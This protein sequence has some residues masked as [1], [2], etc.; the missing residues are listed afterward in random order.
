MSLIEGVGDE[1]TAV[2]AVLLLLFVICLAWISTNIRDIPFFSVIIVELTNGARRRA[3]AANRRDSP[4]SD[5]DDASSEH[6]QE[7]Q[8]V[9]EAGNV[10]EELPGN[11]EQSLPQ[12]VTAQA[13]NFGTEKRAVPESRTGE[14]NSGENVSGKDSS[15]ESVEQ[16]ALSTDLEKENS[17][18]KID[19]DLSETEL[20]R[21]RVEFFQRQ[22]SSK[23]P[24][25]IQASVNQGNSSQP[26]VS[27]EE[28]PQT[29]IDASEAA[30]CKASQSENS[31]NS[32]SESSDLNQSD[33][34]VIN[35][36][37]S[38][39]SHA[40]S[41]SVVN[42]G[43]SKGCQAD[44]KK[45]KDSTNSRGGNSGQSN[46]HQSSDPLDGES[47]GSQINIRL[48]Y[49]NDTQR[50]VI[51][52]PNDTIG[53]FRRANFAAE[54]SE[55]KLVRF[56]FNG[57]DLRN[58][59]NTL[60]AYNIVDNS[61]IHCL[62]TQANRNAE[63]PRMQHDDNVFD[64]GM[65]MLPLFGLL[66][67]LVWYLR[68]EYRQFFTATSTVSLI[69][70]L[71][72]N[73]IQV[74]SR[75][76]NDFIN[77]YLQQN[78]FFRNVWVTSGMRSTSNP[79]FYGWNGDY[80]NNLITP[81]RQ[82]WIDTTSS[83][84]RIGEIIVYRFDG[85]NYGWD[86]GVRIDKYSYICEISQTEAFRLNPEKRGFDY[87]VSF[88]DLDKVRR[89]PVFEA[90]GQPRDLTVI[91]RGLFALLECRA[92][93]YPQPNYKWMRNK[94][95]NVTND[96]SSINELITSDTDSRYTLTNGRFTIQSPAAEADSG[97]YVCVAE[98][99]VGKIISNPVT[100]S[101]GYLGEF[102]NVR[103][104]DVNAQAY[105]GTVIKCSNI[106][107]RPALIYN[108]RRGRNE[109]R[110]EYIYTETTP[111][112][113]MSYNGQLYFSEVTR[114]D[115]GL[116]YCQVSL[117][118]LGDDA[119]GLV[120]A[121]SRTSRGIRL[122]V[123]AQA[124]KTDW[125]PKIQDDFI[126]V[127]PKPPLKG[128]NVR[129]E[130]FAYGSA[131]NYEQM[132]SYS[133]IRKGKP[134]PTTVKFSDFNR[135][136]TIQ[137]AKLEDQGTYTCIVRRG[138]QASDT[139][140]YVLS[141]EA[142]PYFLIPLSHQ[143]AD[144]GSQLTWRCEASGYPPP[145]YRWYRNGQLL[146]SA[147]GDMI[148]SGSTL[149]IQSLDHKHSGMYQ[150]AASNSHGTSMSEA[151]LRV[152]YFAPK[153][154]KNP[155]KDMV[156]ALNG[157]ITIVCE[158]EAAPRPIITWKK[159]NGAISSDGRR[160]IL[161]NGNL[162]ILDLSYADRGFYTCQAENS[163]GKSAS[164]SRLMVKGAT[165]ISRPPVDVTVGVNQTAFL[166][167][168]ASYDTNLD[169]IYL[170][171]KNGMIIDPKHDVHYRYERSS[172]RNGLF[173][174]MVQFKHAGRYECVAKTTLNEASRFATVI[175][176]GPPG[177]PAGLVGVPGSITTNSMKLNF[178]PGTDHGSPTSYYIVQKMNEYSKE[179]ELVE[180]NFGDVTTRLQG[181]AMLEEMRQIYIT[182][183]LPGNGYR[184]RVAAVNK[185][186]VGI[187][188]FP[189]MYLRTLSAPPA[190]PVGDVMGGGG[191]EGV[192]T[193]RW[194]T[195]QRQYHGGPGLKYTVY[196]RKYD[197]NPISEGLWSKVNITNWRTNSTVVQ[198]GLDNYYLLYD[199]KIG[200]MNDFGRGPNSTVTQIYSAEGMP[201]G[202]P[203]NIECDAYNSTAMYIWFDP[204]PDTREA[205]KG[206][207]S[208]YQVNY[209]L[210][211]EEEPVYK[212]YIR[213]PGQ[214]DECVAIGLFPDTN[215]WFEVQ[216]YNSAG[217]GPLSTP[218]IQETL[219]QAPDLY[220]VE[221]QVHSHGS[222]SV[223]L[224]WRGISTRRF[225]RVLAGYKIYLWPA[226]EHYRTAKV[227]ETE[228]FDVEWVLYGIEKNMVYAVRVAGFSDGGD[229]KKSPTVYFTLGGSIAV[230]NTTTSVKYY[231]IDSSADTQLTNVMTLACA[232]ILTMFCLV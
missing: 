140:D 189:S 38:S 217:L 202:T 103:D 127:F 8:E 104:N 63:S 162:H 223:K 73:L 143:H 56:I 86:L 93:G 27:K 204:V 68:F 2:F 186:G 88:A 46:A 58:D 5:S 159:D 79:N 206:R 51:A 34:N 118:S 13:Q 208:G 120:Q 6:A 21:R 182:G 226:N 18:E 175:V 53:Q 220:P 144:K 69:G 90:D 20:R 23:E 116:Y 199:V 36:S 176:V 44:S 188:S 95:G 52:S 98:N 111:Y 145:V 190:N 14:S 130:C 108:W 149:T 1:V 119:V 15:N 193:I 42:S 178:V 168:S 184:F 165:V 211:G 129:M 30:T 183:L 205:M 224:T 198:V 122:N 49:L 125:G 146:R 161:P 65:L 158:P 94:Y 32:Q 227:I 167:C 81:D 47:F 166:Q 45:S 203:Q 11:A 33:S 155:L 195:V 107:Y 40:G 181:S 96:L 59:A 4:V 229:G 173:I 3:T 78:D 105:D 106:N 24:S 89:G 218:F 177:E 12:E 209:W 152:L 9:V 210:D 50:S 131:E 17:E 174:L 22:S 85:V 75:P 221:L 192:L 28:K 169:L 10:I 66:I 132:W 80:E 214:R 114:V 194:L 60:Q 148:V 77:G 31:F 228:K 67:C 121:P 197:P 231:G 100:L 91:S 133:W 185:F 151:Q 137:N 35:Q 43:S 112:V 171:K 71:G 156:G 216:V 76:E 115:E 82:Y 163:A 7:E 179:W 64:I 124:A 160:R 128:Q 225:E 39:S 62:I 83:R 99:T 74:D 187:W 222:E 164:T 136:M 117:T 153:F 150:C 25:I 196:Y 37:D 147:Q 41:S 213:Y 102:S 48:K 138:N 139:K 191:S 19:Q 101:F 113:F 207:I 123:Q 29:V 215:F 142:V 61:V 219:H 134:M 70:L 172:S 109:D 126:A 57:Q 110:A 170:W 230:D 212:R 16:V 154:S 84:S 54:L 55:N 200:V 92:E 135:V 72:T 180:E 87:G 97:Q 141:L 201:P 232:L 26:K 157:E